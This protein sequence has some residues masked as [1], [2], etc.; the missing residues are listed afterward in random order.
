[1]GKGPYEY[2]GVYGTPKGVRVAL[3]KLRKEGW[4][5]DMIRGKQYYLH[6]D[7]YPYKMGKDYA[8]NGANAENCHFSIFSSPQNTK[9]WTQGI[10]E[11]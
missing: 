5:L 9:L 11:A 1:M 7:K 2:K 4:E 8:L 6:R 10:R 3:R